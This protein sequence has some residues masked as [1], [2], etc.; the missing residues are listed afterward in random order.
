MSTLC[1]IGHPAAGHINPTL[2]VVSELVRRGE[3]AVYFATEPF[4]S[5]IEATGASFRTY[6]EQGLFERNLSQGGMLGGMAGLMQTTEEILPALIAQVQEEDPD[7]LLVEAHAVWG[8]LLAQFLD[9]PTA[10][11]CSM[12]AMSEKLL[13]TRELIDH[14]YGSASCD[15]ALGGMIGLSIYAETA[16]RVAR[17]YGTKCPGMIDYLGNPQPLN[18]VFTSREFQI[19]GDAFDDR[20]SFVG[21][22]IPES[23]GEP[24]AGIDSHRPLIYVS[25]GTMYNDEADLYRECFR[26]FG[27]QNMQ[28]V[29]AVGHRV[30]RSKLADVP[31]NFV[32]REYVPQMAVLSNA[33]LFITHGGINSAHEAM[34]NGVPMIVL[35]RSADHFVVA[36]QVAAAGAGIVL[37]RSEATAERLME[38]KSAVLANPAYRHASAAMG[39]SLRAA[40]G[41]RRAADEILNYAHA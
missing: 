35:P 17:R 29:M 16:R 27:N 2:P 13:Q 8:N 31:P 40:G 12:F 22:S 11:L 10:T 15:A 1:V 38:L 23:H 19:G 18:I 32:I 5:R 26:A 34:L 7:Y 3:R 39:Q 28:V 25:M 41:Y 30:D 6:G 33:D 24:P 9:V 36:G 20:Y 21:P 37:H 14:L 4:R